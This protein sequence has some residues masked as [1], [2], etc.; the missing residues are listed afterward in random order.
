[1]MFYDDRYS[2]IGDISK[3]SA[4]QFS[5]KCGLEFICHREPYFKMPFMAKVGYLISDLLRFDYLAYVD[6]DVLFNPSATALWPGASTYNLCLSTDSYGICAG[7]L[8]VKN[9]EATMRLLKAWKLL[10]KTDDCASQ[11]D[12][13]TL[14]LL[15]QKFAWVRSLVCEIP[16]SQVSNDDCRNMVG[17]VA[18]HFWCNVRGPG[19]VAEKMLKFSF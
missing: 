13:A 5:D 1:M 17:S 9:S 4:K 15:I 12:Q 2:V 3:I 16:M 7:V 8:S 6:S 11:H 18:H 10:G 14:K 19:S